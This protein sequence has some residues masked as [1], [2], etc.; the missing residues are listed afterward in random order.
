MNLR[1]TIFNLIYTLRI[2]HLI[3]ALNFGLE[4]IPILLFHDINPEGNKL[5]GALTPKQFEEIIVFLKKK[6]KIADLREFKSISNKNIC[7]ITF[8]DGMSNFYKYALDIV[9]KHNVPIT[10]FIPTNCISSGT[11]WNLK[12]FYI[13]KINKKKSLEM[14]IENYDAIDKTNKISGF[15]TS[16]D[17]SLMTWAQLMEI[18]YDNNI[19]IQSHSNNHYFLSSL[20]NTEQQKE[21]SISKN[22]IHKKL[23]IEANS[24]AYPMGD[25]N[26]TTIS[27][28]KELY[29]FG[30]RTGDKLAN[31]KT[32]K[33]YE[34]PRITIHDA[35]IKEL[36][37]KINGIHA[38]LKKIKN[39]F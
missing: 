12:Y 5:T 27:L 3:H 26:N 10:L 4:R 36:Y 29:S 33:K 37:A 39:Y 34:I 28:A 11:T 35:E 23:N 9:K 18:S 30:F 8:D 19:N 22:K 1:S 13:T 24:I 2:P 38:F 17:F 6:Y 32:I 7:Y 15:N 16:E 20:S 21:L 14:T 31:L 25:Y